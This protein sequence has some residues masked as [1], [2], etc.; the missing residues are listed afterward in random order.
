MF[1]WLRCPGKLAWQAG[2][3]LGSPLGHSER[4]PQTCLRRLSQEGSQGWETVAPG[5]ARRG[6]CGFRP[7]CD[8][9]RGSLEA[10][11]PAHSR[12]VPSGFGV[13][14]GPRAALG[15]LGSLLS[16]RS[17]WRLRVPPPAF[18]PSLL[19]PGFKGATGLL[20]R[21]ARP[22]SL[23]CSPWR[24]GWNQEP[25]WSR[26]SFLFCLQGG[27][28]EGAGFWGPCWAVSGAGIPAH[29]DGVGGGAVREGPHSE[30]L[31]P[32]RQVALTGGTGEGLWGWQGH[33]SA[34]V[35]VRYPWPMMGSEL[36]ALDKGGPS[37]N[38]DVPSPGLTW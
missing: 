11:P 15:A 20:G 18:H 29:H 9:S 31:T 7:L 35:L 16:E 5:G 36:G 21:K 2:P 24:R 26:G 28:S 34:S 12:Q 23:P 10:D 22:F 6:W 30:T 25:P 3:S 14:E 37:Q 19:S 38:P 13:G 33:L 8:A 17:P 4:P 27:S 32:R 1:S